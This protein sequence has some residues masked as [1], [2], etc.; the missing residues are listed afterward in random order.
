MI[1]KHIP[2]CK[3]KFPQNVYFFV[4][5]KRVKELRCKTSILVLHRS[6]SNLP[7]QKPATSNYFIS[8][9]T[10]FRSLSFCSICF[11]FRQAIRSSSSLFFSVIIRITC[12]VLLYPCNSFKCLELFFR[13]HFVYQI[14]FSICNG[15]IVIGIVGVIF[16][17]CFISV[18]ICEIYC[19]F[20]VC[21]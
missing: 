16:Y 8:Y 3:S 21:V 19:H 13:C 4:K 12:T 9:P 15:S 6:S 20:R 5:P 7:H 1:V 11:V 18:N 2:R 10:R 14:C 17:G